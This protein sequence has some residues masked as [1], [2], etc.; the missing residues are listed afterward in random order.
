MCPI[1]VHYT[2]LIQMLPKLMLGDQRQ[3]ID[4]SKLAIQTEVW[5][6]HHGSEIYEYMKRQ[7]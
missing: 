7:E 3:R 2:S 5:E 1:L 6:Q 4:S